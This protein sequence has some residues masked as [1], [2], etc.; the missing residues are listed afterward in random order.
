MVRRAERAMERHIPW[1]EAGR[2]CSWKKKQIPRGNTSSA[3]KDES[4]PQAKA[5]RLVD[6]KKGAGKLDCRTREG[7]GARRLLDDSGLYNPGV[8]DL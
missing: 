5:V 6:S 4:T 7:L 1:E 8:S 2:Q 3:R